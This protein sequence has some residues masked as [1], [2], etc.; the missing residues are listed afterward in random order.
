MSIDGATRETYE[1]IRQGA[2]FERFIQNVRDIGVVR[3]ETGYPKHIGFSFTATRTNLPE[4]AG[5]VRLAH[6]LG[7]DEVFS[8]ASM[9][10]KDPIIEAR[11]RD[12]HI[13]TMPREEIQRHMSEARDVAR[14]L[15]VQ[16]HFAVAL[17]PDTILD[18]PPAGHEGTVVEK[19]TEM[20]VDV[21][22]CQYPWRQPFQLVRE[23]DRYTLCCSLRC[24]ML[25]QR[26]EWSLRHATVSLTTPSGL[27]MKF[28]TRRS[29]WDL[30]R[31]L[32]TGKPLRPLR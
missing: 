30:R 32:A 20:E 18:T 15:G 17:D 8:T 10:M 28:T 24:Y 12:I 11:I 9:E 5:V 22:M 2:V 31:D 14:A 29:T 27:S 4:L 16:F 13:D 23:V 19:R 26:G 3:R 21:R 25:L 6:E 1:A 7:G